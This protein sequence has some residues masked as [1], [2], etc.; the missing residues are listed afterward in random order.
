MYDRVLVITINS[1]YSKVP[2]TSTAVLLKSTVPT[3]AF[4]SI[5]FQFIFLSFTLFLS[6]TFRL[7]RFFFHYLKF[8]EACRM[9]GKNY[10]AYTISVLL[11]LFITSYYCKLGKKV[12]TYTLFI[13]L[14]QVT[15]VTNHNKKVIDTIG[16]T[17]IL[18]PKNNCEIIICMELVHILDH[19][20]G[21]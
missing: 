10:V 16:Y 18:L 5:F 14:R 1:Y 17:K 15:T 3:I 8:R 2:S 6:S 21:S 20:L 13:I 12:I 7:F 4:S 11:G 9:D 19:L